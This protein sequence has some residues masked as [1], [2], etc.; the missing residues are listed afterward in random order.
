MKTDYLPSILRREF[1]QIR[2]PARKTSLPKA[3]STVWIP[4][5]ANI[6]TLKLKDDEDDEIDAKKSG[7]GKTSK[8]D[9]NSKS[10]TVGKP[11]K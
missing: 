9:V 3:T 5:A 7:G 11:S 4:E 8:K 2:T 6:V 10:A 1:G